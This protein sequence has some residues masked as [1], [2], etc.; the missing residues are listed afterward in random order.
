MGSDRELANTT[1]VEVDTSGNC[2]EC[3]AELTPVCPTCN[4]LDGCNAEIVGMLREAAHRV[5]G[6]NCAFAD[7]DLALLEHMAQRAADAGLTDG[8]SP[9]VRRHTETPH[10]RKIEA[11]PG[12]SWG[13]LIARVTGNPPA[14]GPEA[15]GNT[16]QNQ[17]SEP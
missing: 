11:R 10:D 1:P 13:E 5:F 14:D 8:L 9:D 7:D 2:F 15:H 16:V 6:G 17:R 3:G 12:K 4:D